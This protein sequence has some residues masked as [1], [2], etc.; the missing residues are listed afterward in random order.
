MSGWDKFWTAITSAVLFA[1]GTFAL[2]WLATIAGCARRPP[3]PAAPEHE[4][5]R[6]VLAAD[7]DNDWLFCVED[8]F[9][10]GTLED[11]VIRTGLSCPW[12]V[13]EVRLMVSR[14]KVAD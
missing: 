13:W 12:R 8:P 4:P 11:P 9:L 3:V 6:V 1:L 2:L 14:L 5:F 7:A 10:N